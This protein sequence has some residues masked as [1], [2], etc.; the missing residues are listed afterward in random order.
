MAKFHLLVK[1]DVHFARASSS[2]AQDAIV[3]AGMAYPMSFS[4]L[5]LGMYTRTSNGTLL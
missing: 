5:G 4:Y 1:I 2:L 3:V